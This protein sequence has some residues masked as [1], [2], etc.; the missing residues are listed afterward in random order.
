MWRYAEKKIYNTLLEWK[1]T[2][3]RECL[4]VKG[5]TLSL[6]NFIK[7]YAPPFAYKLISGSVG[8][9]DTK[10]TLPLYMTMFIW[11]KN[12]K[13]RET[14]LTPSPSYFYEH[15]SAIDFII[16][17]FCS[18]VQG[19]F[20]MYAAT[21]S[22]WTSATFFLSSSLSFLFDGKCTITFMLKPP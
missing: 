13:K 19:C 4:L 5:A 14:V 2:K 9:S 16:K 11:T 21:L 1:N 20:F 8:V 12:K 10:I 22:P 15:L 7:N 3:S 18:L 6:N 17:S